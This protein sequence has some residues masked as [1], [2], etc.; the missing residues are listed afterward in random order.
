MGDA[1]LV[2]DEEG[3]GDLAAGVERVAGRGLLTLV[4]DQAGADQDG[5][6]VGS[7]VGVG[8]VFGGGGA[9]RG[10]VGAAVLG[11]GGDGQAGQDVAWSASIRPVSVIESLLVSVNGVSVL[12]W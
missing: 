9:Q 3:V 1:V 12:D 7:L 8:V 4:D 11:P 10:E 6:G 5:G 2:G